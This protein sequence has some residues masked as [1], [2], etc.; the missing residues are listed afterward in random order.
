MGLEVLD[1]ALLQP[2]GNVFGPASRVR[3]DEGG[4]MLVDQLAEEVIHPSIRDLHRY[5]GFF[6]HPAQNPEGAGPPRVDPHD[7][8]VSD[9]AALVA[10]PGFFLLLPRR[11]RPAPAAPPQDA[12][13]PLAQT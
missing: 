11:A 6:T 3:E 7:V 2:E 10:P 12:P 1:A 13:R 8:H 4:A 5:G 9:P